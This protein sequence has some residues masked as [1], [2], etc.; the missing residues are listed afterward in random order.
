LAGR[1]FVVPDDVKRLVVP[2]LRHRLVLRPESALRGR[3]AND[4]LEAI[5]TAV[6]IDEDA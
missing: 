4:V 2:V 6:P 3:T 1:Q 5:L